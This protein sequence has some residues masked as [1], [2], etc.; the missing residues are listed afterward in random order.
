ER[1]PWRGRGRRCPGRPSSARLRTRRRAGRRR[2][3]P[4]SRSRARGS[5]GGS[6]PGAHGD[7]RSS[8]YLLE[9]R[10]RLRDLVGVDG[11]GWG[12]ADDRRPGGGD[13]ETGVEASRD[14][15]GRVLYFEREQEPLPTHG[16]RLGEL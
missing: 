16:E 13:E 9:D 1:A 4:A 14:R 3:P 12:D 8:H 10:D 2:A 5:G 15:L 11:Q 7:V 6:R